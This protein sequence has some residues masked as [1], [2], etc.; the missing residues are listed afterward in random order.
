[1]TEVT[2]ADIEANVEAVRK[3][4]EKKNRDRVEKANRAKTEKVT[5]R[6]QAT[7]LG[8]TQSDELDISAQIEMV[9]SCQELIATIE[10]EIRRAEGNEEEEKDLGGY[11]TE[12]TA[13][14]DGV[15]AGFEKKE[16]VE[17]GAK[18]RH[19]PL[20][21]KSTH[22]F[23]R[24][25]EE[26][27]SFEKI[28][29]ARGQ[30]A[31]DEQKEA[32]KERKRLSP[33]RSRHVF[34]VHDYSPQGNTTHYFRKRWFEGEAGKEGLLEANFIESEL[35]DLIRRIG[36]DRD[37]RK[38]VLDNLLKMSKGYTLDDIWEGTEGAV[39]RLTGVNAENPWKVPGRNGQPDRPVGGDVFARVVGECEVTFL[40]PDRS[41]LE[42][43][44][45]VYL[46]LVEDGIQKEIHVEPDLKTVYAVTGGRLKSLREV[47]RFLGHAMSQVPEM[48]EEPTPSGAPEQE[49]GEAPEATSTGSTEAAAE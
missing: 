17:L 30:T 16:L 41:A 4:L 19:A 21:W 3:R 20:S 38:E 2:L 32:K 10:K 36:A 25:A 48:D 40:M 13:K 39:V 18:M 47:V 7:A 12:A 5:K 29:A 45:K 9:S 49:E 27:G 35:Y 8:A 46:G 6:R 28:D 42:H 37:K 23:L 33:E 34:V 14:M 31:I 43:T 1:M 26:R 22:Y 15:L 11:L 44:M 24:K